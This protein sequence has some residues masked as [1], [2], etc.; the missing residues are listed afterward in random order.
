MFK[1][2]WLRSKKNKKNQ[3]SKKRYTEIPPDQQSIKSAPDYE[4]V[5]D[6]DANDVNDVNNEV[7]SEPADYRAASDYGEDRPDGI[8]GNRSVE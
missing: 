1:N 2:K 5:N 4:G 6:N 7:Y 8:Q 3:A